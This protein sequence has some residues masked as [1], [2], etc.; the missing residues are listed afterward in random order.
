[1]I[2]RCFAF[3]IGSIVA[4]LAAGTLLPV[5]WIVYSDDRSV[6]EFGV[7]LGLMTTFVKPVLGVLTVPISCLTFGIFS[8][9]LNGVLFWV[10]ANLAPDIAVTW[11]GAIAGGVIA[12]VINGVMYS[13]VDE[14]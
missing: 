2:T 8:V 3:T 6:I 14:K 5:D 10:A 9:I 11:P 1:M 13:V 4:I 7:L 12:V